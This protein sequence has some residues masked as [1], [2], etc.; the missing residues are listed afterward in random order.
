MH[1]HT[2]IKITHTVSNISVLTQFTIEHSSCVFN[3]DTHC[4]IPAGASITLH[5]TYKSNTSLVLVWHQLHAVAGVANVGTYCRLQLCQR[6]RHHDDNDV[7]L[8]VV[9]F[10][11]IQR[12]HTRRPS[13]WLSVR[14]CHVIDVGRTWLLASRSFVLSFFTGFS[15]A[16]LS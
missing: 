7:V 5:P 1:T 12:L 16:A 4:M 10:H 15:E 2:I 8:V 6:R 13:F 14:R 11:V 9:Q 3:A